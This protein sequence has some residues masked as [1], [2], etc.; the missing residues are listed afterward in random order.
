MKRLTVALFAALFTA[1][2]ISALRADDAASDS[3]FLKEAASGG[4]LEVKLGELAVQQAEN[5]E[6]RRFGQRMVTD[7]TKA[8]KQL[9]SVAEK[10]NVTLATALNSKDQA[11]YNKFRD[12][13]GADF[14]KAYIAN[15]VKDHEHDV[16]EFT[17]CSK[18]AENQQLRE[19]AAQTLPT[20][21]EHLRQAR[22]IATKIGAPESR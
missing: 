15:M 9:T 12:L 7:H 5:A 13:K 11:T 14:D 17:K 16:A 3:K 1:G 2:G 22:S 18:N 19:F 21:E 8:N 20:L 10:A 6:V 4:M